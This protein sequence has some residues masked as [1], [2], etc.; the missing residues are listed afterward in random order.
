[1][2]Y[3]HIRAWRGRKLITESVY[4]AQRGGSV[5]IKCRECY[6]WTTIN[7]VG[8]EIPAH[9]TGYDLEP[10]LARV[11]EEANPTG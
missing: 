4:T 10:D 5:R 1:M 3:V 7:V 6:R 11:L 9:T 2:A 8:G